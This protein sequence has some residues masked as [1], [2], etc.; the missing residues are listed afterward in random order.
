MNE[1]SNSRIWKRG[2]DELGRNHSNHLH[3]KTILQKKKNL[4]KDFSTEFENEENFI[5]H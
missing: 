5:S 4:P 2:E 1:W 3:N